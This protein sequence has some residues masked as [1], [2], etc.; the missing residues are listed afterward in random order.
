M[1]GVGAP[2]GLPTGSDIVT[3]GS[4]FPT[5]G[6][7]ATPATDEGLSSTRATPT[8]SMAE[9]H[10]IEHMLHD[11]PGTIEELTKVLSKMGKDG[12]MFAG[13][14]NMINPNSRLFINMFVFCK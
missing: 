13:Q 8:K 4:V 11:M 7:L 9:S 1:A 10:V 3:E 2:V 5:A 12:W 14:V 6:L